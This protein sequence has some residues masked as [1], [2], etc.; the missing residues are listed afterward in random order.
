[1]KKTLLVLLCTAGILIQASAQKN[2]SNDFIGHW[3]DKD[4]KVS[5]DIVFWK[6]KYGNYQMVSWD[7]TDGEMLEVSNLN[8]KNKTLKVKTKTISTNWVIERT[9]VVIDENNLKE[10]I[11][12]ATDAVIYWK[13]LE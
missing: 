8:A 9:F 1:M 10:T 11:T 5:T 2:A 3:T 12:G 6:D 13:R 4:E 7:K